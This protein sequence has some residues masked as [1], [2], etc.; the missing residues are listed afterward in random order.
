MLKHKHVCSS[1]WTKSNWRCWKF[2]FNYKINSYYFFS[3]D[4]CNGKKNIFA[5]QNNVTFALQTDSGNMSEYFLSKG[6]VWRREKGELLALSSR[7]RWQSHMNW[8]MNK[9]KNTRLV[10]PFIRNGISDLLTGLSTY[11]SCNFPHCCKTEFPLFS[12]PSW[13]MRTA[14]N[15]YFLLKSDYSSSCQHASVHH[16]C[17]LQF[18]F[19][20]GN[21]N[22]NWLLKPLHLIR[23]QYQRKWAGITV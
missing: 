15:L 16:A 3:C 6:G 9:R 17:I 2:S 12:W 14:V 10:F 5:C 19:A 1:Q 4:A 20:E 23:N 8:C 18:V 22:Q 11:Q 21:R 7:N 13:H